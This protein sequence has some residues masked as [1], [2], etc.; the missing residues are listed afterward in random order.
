MT[1]PFYRGNSQ[2]T[3]FCISFAEFQNWKREASAADETCK[4]LSCPQD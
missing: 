3:V 2:L 4:D 1:N